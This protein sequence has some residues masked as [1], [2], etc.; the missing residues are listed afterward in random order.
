MKKKLSPEQLKVLREKATEAPFSGK[1]LYNKE[2]G[3]YFCAYCGTKLFSSDA[4]FDSSCGWP[5]FDK[6]ENVELKEDNSHGMNRVEVVCKKC[7][8]HLGH[9]F[10]DGKTETKKRYCINSIALDFKKEKKK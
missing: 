6:A 7:G 2:N 9:L 10:D 4:K 5:S 3:N 1:L 8:S